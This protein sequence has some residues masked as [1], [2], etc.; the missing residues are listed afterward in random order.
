M[1]LHSSLLAIAVLAVLLPK[2][3]EASALLFTDRATFQSYHA[4]L[5]LPP[6]ALEKF[7]APVWDNQELQ[8]DACVMHVPGLA[9]NHDCH[10]GSV[11]F[12]DAEPLGF[13]VFN[14]ANGF[15]VTA[16]FAQP[17]TAIGLDY[18]VPACDVVVG[19]DVVDFGFSNGLG[20]RLSG[21]GFRGIIDTSNPITSMGTDF[22]D[23]AGVSGNGQ[24]A[25]ASP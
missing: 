12:G 2:S 15:P 13:A 9:I 7:E 22:P 23:F 8:R 17:Q 16:D 1:R 24:P 4:L 5:G 21:S 10:D 3:A 6:L 20:F 19:C 11:E 25:P 18:S 14:Q